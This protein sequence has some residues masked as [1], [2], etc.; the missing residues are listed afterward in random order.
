[1]NWGNLWVAEEDEVIRE[2]YG[3]VKIDDMVR[4]LPRHPLGSIHKR[5]QKLKVKGNPALA[6][7]KYT[8][9]EKF[10]SFLTPTSC[11]W[12]GFIAAD[13]CVGKGNSIHVSLSRKDENHLEKF[14]SD[15]GYNGT[16]KR[17]VSVSELGNNVEWSRVNIWGVPEWIEVLQETFS[18]TPRKSLTLQPPVGLNIIQSMYYIM[19][20]VDGD[21]SIR[22][23][24]SHI[25]KDGSQ[26][27]GF[28][29]ELVGTRPLLEWAREVFS[30]LVPSTANNKIF[31]T[32]NFPVLKYR[33]AKAKALCEKFLELPC[34]QRMERKW[35]NAKR[36]V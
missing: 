7:K 16:I 10:F 30:S 12:A 24:K 22:W 1:M 4:R 33:G 19:G 17:G 29:F 6:S 3:K 15:I 11:Y 23:N 14:I 9:N 8:I 35:S 20:Y 21:G 27:F 34:S 31:L 36:I 28:H 32:N 25:R 13:G 2:W 5:A 26:A 18:I